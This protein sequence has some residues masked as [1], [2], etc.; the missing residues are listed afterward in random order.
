M[1]PPI[2]RITSSA[3][4]ARYAGTALLFKRAPADAAA[5]GIFHFFEKKIDLAKIG[6]N[7]LLDRFWA[8]LGLKFGFCVKNC[9][10]TS[11][12]IDVS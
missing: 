2:F 5:G 3:R 6:R 9:T 12:Q 7:R 4:F 1:P 8:D 10:G 11:V